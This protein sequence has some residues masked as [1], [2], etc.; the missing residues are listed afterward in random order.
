MAQLLTYTEPLQLQ[1]PMQLKVM[2]KQET[3]E[4]HLKKLYELSIKTIG[5]IA[6]LVKPNQEQ[7]QWIDYKLKHS[8]AWAKL[9]ENKIGDWKSWRS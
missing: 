1:F 6:E 3:R 2:T 7:K 5:E 9:S 4:Y 8:N